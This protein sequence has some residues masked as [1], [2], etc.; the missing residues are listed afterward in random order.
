F[1]FVNSQWLRLE[2][3]LT[4][5]R[6]VYTAQARQGIWRYSLTGRNQFAG[7][8]GAS[9]DVNG[10]PIVPIGAYDVVA[11][12]PQHRGLD[13]AVQALINLTPLPNN[14]NTVG[15][16]L[17]TAGY[18]WSAPERERQHDWV[19]KIDHVSTTRITPFGRLSRG[20]QITS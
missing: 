10:N 16:G 17:N 15:D 9:V 13:P 20:L 5:N 1:F 7:I 4:Q 2:R 18:T 8:A 6:T 3:T 14:F 11:N 19:T 12:D